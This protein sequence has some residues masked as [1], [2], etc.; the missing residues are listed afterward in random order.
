MVMPIGSGLD[1]EGVPIATDG[2]SERNLESGLCL[3]FNGSLG[4]AW[5]GGGEARMEPCFPG[6][7]VLAQPS[8]YFS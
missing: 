4:G 3:C 5:D 7:A 2:A 8:S 6:P 1:V